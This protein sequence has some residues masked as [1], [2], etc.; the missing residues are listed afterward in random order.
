[1]QKSHERVDIISFY[2]LS[3][4][5]QTEELDLDCEAGESN[6]FVTK[7]GTVYSLDGFMRTESGRFDGVMGL[8]NT[9]AIGLILAADGE[10]A[11]I[12][13]IG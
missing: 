13:F 8:T 4:E 3:P 7:T 11:V 10:E 1:M 2:E 6:Y 12:R 5:Q 9:S